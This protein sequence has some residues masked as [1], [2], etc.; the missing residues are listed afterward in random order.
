HRSLAA[1]AAPGERVAAPRP[2]AR[3]APRAVL[4]VRQQPRRAAFRTAPAVAWVLALHVRHM[5]EAR[6]IT[7]RT[8]LPVVVHAVLALGANARE[9]RDAEEGVAAIAAPGTR[10]H[11]LRHRPRAAIAAEIQLQPAREALHELALPVLL[12][13][14]PAAVRVRRRG[15]G[16]R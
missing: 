15:A 1:R 9:R 12:P 8:E 3:V 7:P 16:M 10:H 14:E 13:G 5:A 2:H 6:S 11:E 4:H